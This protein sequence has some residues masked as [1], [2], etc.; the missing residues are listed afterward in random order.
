MIESKKMQAQQTPSKAPPK[1]ISN[2]LAGLAINKKI[3][4]Y[5]SLFVYYG[6]TGC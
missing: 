5:F 1:H 4:P 3:W 6:N 2:V